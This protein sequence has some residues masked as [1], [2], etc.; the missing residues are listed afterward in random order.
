MAVS[1]TTMP[2][3][4]YLLLM[5]L[6]FD[7]H[8]QGH[9]NR[10]VEA[11]HMA[12]YL[13]NILPSTTIDNEIPHTRLYKTTPNYADLHVFGCL[14][15]PHIDTNN[16]L[17][18]RSTPSIFLGTQPPAS[19]QVPESLVNLD[20]YSTPKE[21]DLDAA[22]PSPTSPAHLIPPTTV[23]TVVIEIPPLTT[24]NIV[25]LENDIRV[26]DFTS[27]EKDSVV[28]NPSP[29]SS[30]LL[31]P[32]TTVDSTII[33]PL[34][35]LHNIS[36]PDIDTSNSYHDVKESVASQMSPATA[37]DDSSAKEVPPVKEVHLKPIMGNVVTMSEMHEI[38]L[39]NRDSLFS[40]N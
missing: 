20:H 39:Y 1:L 35:T 33:S 36:T 6:P 18:P 8:V 31:T 14:C 16:K 15:Y 19:S 40:H 32:P 27:K 24:L 7:S 37:A 17:G 30:T 2:Y 5:A 12:A 9:L 28:A 23:D 21:I 34:T 38:L 3:T 25:G 22:S 4:K 11:L 29:S 10:I 13:L 26:N